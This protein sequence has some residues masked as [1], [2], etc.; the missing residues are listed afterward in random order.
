MDIKTGIQSYITALKESNAASANTQLAYQ[1]DLTQFLGFL[2]SDSKGD[3]DLSH[4]SED[5]IDKYLSD[6]SQKNYSDTTVARKTAALKSFFRWAVE[7][8]LTDKSFASKL[9]P[10]TLGYKPPRI[11]SEE[12]VSRIINQAGARG[13]SRAKRDKAL[14]AVLYD[15]GM[16]VSETTNLKMADIDLESGKI[17]CL[18]GSPKQRVVMMSQNTRQIVADYLASARPSLMSEQPSD[19]LFLNPF[20][21]GL[22]RQAVWIMIRRNAKNAGITGLVTPHTLRHSRAAHLLAAGEDT[23]KVKAYF[24]HANM[25]TTQS[26][27][28]ERLN[29]PPPSVTPEA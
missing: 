23:R 13:T 24:G 17:M 1:T 10:P 3:I 9:K 22:T 6:L 16:R 25:A 28:P 18:V 21:S 7:N 8:N 11:L 14:L 19:D 20:G 5:D 26:Y 29:P 2:S 15:T 4:I 27:L 12:E